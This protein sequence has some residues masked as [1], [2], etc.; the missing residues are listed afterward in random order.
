MG[1]GKDQLYDANC[2]PFAWT[3]KC[4]PSKSGMRSKKPQCFSRQSGN[5]D[6]PNLH[7]RLLHRTIWQTT[8]HGLALCKLHTSTIAYFAIISN[9]KFVWFLV[10][11]RLVLQAHYPY[12]EHFH[13]RKRLWEWRI[14]GHFKRRHPNF[15]RSP[16]FFVD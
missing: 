3:Q 5:I 6:K 12:K 7:L 2:E 11:I 8:A 4:D 16:D 14:Q 9:N 13:G 1:S 15:I 10:S